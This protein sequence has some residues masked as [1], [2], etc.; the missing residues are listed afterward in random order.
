[1]VLTSTRRLGTKQLSPASFISNALYSF[2]DTN[3]VDSPL[4]RYERVCHVSCFGSTLDLLIDYMC[5]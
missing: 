1:M 5:H 3:I 2:T 4:V